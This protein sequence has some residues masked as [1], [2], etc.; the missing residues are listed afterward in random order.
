[1]PGREN[2]PIHVLSS[3]RHARMSL[4]VNYAACTQTL[5]KASRKQIS[6]KNSLGR[7]PADLLDDVVCTR[8]GRVSIHACVSMSVFYSNA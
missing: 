2:A 6:A 1:M 3:A 4:I 8:A 7:T 5:A